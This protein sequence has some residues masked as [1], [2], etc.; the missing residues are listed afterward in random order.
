VRFW[1]VIGSQVWLI[2]QPFVYLCCSIRIRTSF[3]LVCD[4]YSTGQ[5]F[6][7]VQLNL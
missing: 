7:T 1:T 3:V 6:A 4:A 5:V 2:I